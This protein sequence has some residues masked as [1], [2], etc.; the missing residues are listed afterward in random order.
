VTHH[1]GEDDIFSKFGM[2]RNDE[3]TLLVSVRRFSIVGQDHGLKQ[4]LEDD[5]IYMPFS[6]TL[7][8][9]RKVKH[10]EEYFQFGQN[11]VWRLEVGLF[12]PSHETFENDDITPEDLQQVARQV[13]DLGL[14]SLLGI[15]E[16]LKQDEGEVFKEVIEQSLPTTF[17]SDNPF[18]E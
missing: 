13:D 4:P 14:T 8:K 3:A 10:D 1:N 12:D 6:N 17:D 16:E 11:R 7:W 9:I 15:S 5:V 2:V 18:G